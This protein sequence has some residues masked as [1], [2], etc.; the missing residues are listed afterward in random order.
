MLKYTVTVSNRTI[1]RQDWRVACFGLPDD[2]WNALGTRV[3]ESTH[4]TEL[5]ARKEAK[6]VAAI[7]SAE[8]LP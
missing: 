5:A 7:W 3:H 1:I 4:R 8:V 6:R 2:D